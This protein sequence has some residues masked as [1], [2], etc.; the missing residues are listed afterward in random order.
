M[1]SPARL[2]GARALRLFTQKAVFAANFG[3]QC[4]QFPLQGLFSGPAGP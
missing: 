1:L 2:I 3:S 4:Q